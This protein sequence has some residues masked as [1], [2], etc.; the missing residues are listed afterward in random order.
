MKTLP[1]IL[2]CFTF[3][4]GGLFAQS[5]GFTNFIR[6]V[7]TP[8]GVQWDVSVAA[9]GAQQ[10]GL[11]VESGGARFELWT[12]KAS[13]LT[14]YL[15][16]TKFVGAYIPVSSVTIRSE[17]PYSTI[18]RTRA[19]R[20]FWV[21]ITVSGLSSVTT[22]PDA[23]KKIQLLRHV[24]SYGEGGIGLNLNR[25]QATLLTTS[26]L[27]ANGSQTLS[28]AVT[29]VPGTDLTKLRGEERFSAFSLA[30]TL[31]PQSQLASQYIQI[32]PVA[33]GTIAG[34]AENELIRTKMPSVTLNVQDVYPSS[35]IYA[36][37]YQ[38]SPALGVEGARLSA[39]WRNSENYP[40]NKTLV[41]SSDDLDSPVRADGTWTLELL[42]DTPFGITRLAKVSFTLKRSIKV[43]ASVTTM[44]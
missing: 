27:T 35:T 24:Q 30:D 1:R 3:L 8:S 17:D 40:Q 42:T 41:L 36:Q 28:Y 21:D 32:W 11:A 20:P 43:N 13:P 10:S 22:A 6:Q 16:D 37:V 31:S 44:E 26:Y 38:G 14:S 29:S 4:T 33:A 12:V 2:S 19:D 15:L 25:T 7:Q 39:Q 9:T 34:I 5:T 18:P 23:A